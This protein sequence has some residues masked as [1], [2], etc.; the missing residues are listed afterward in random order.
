M[1]EPGLTPTSTKKPFPADVRA[2]YSIQLPKTRGFG[3]QP[4]SQTFK[5]TTIPAPD[6][7]R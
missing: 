1:S 2:E 3:L 4:A 6:T 7:V 5:L